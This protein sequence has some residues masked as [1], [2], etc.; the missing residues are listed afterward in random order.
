MNKIWGESFRYLLLIF[1]PVLV[2]CKIVLVALITYEYFKDVLPTMVGRFGA[3]SSLFITMLGLYL[4]ICI[5]FNYLMA[6]WV[7]PGHPSD[8]LAGLYPPCKKCEKPKPP[9]A[10]HCSVC[11]KCVLKMDHHCPWI[12]NCVGH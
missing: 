9:R 7:G 3:G 5:F 1:G 10:H 12:N 11:N 8:N 2:V 6:V 4:L